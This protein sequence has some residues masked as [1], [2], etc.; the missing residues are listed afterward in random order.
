MTNLPELLRFP[1]VVVEETTVVVIVVT[2]FWAVLTPPLDY[3][4]LFTVV[5][6]VLSVILMFWVFWPDCWAF[7]VALDAVTVAVVLPTGFVSLVAGLGASPP[8]FAAFISAAPLLLGGGAPKPPKSIL[9]KSFSKLVFFRSA[10]R[11]TLYCLYL[12]AHRQV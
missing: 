10:S 4:D 1:L 8:W 9:S 11:P 7:D 6:K 3:V 2:P 5:I 12:D